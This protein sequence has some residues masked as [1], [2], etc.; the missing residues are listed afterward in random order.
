MGK[1]NKLEN[2]FQA[3]WRGF[4]YNIICV[5]KKVFFLAKKLVLVLT[6]L[7]F[8]CIMMFGIILYSIYLEKLIL[9]DIDNEKNDYRR[10]YR[11]QPCSLCV[12]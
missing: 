9:E 3:I 11:R 5:A 4:N 12:Q 7:F 8:N 1:Y 2:F 6:I 10:Q